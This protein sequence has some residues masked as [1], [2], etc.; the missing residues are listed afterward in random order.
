MCRPIANENVKDEN[1]MTRTSVRICLFICMFACGAIAQA[2]DWYVSPSGSSQGNGSLTSPWDLR[3]ALSA[4]AAVQP[5]DT[6][7]VRGGTY[8]GAFNSYLSGR[9]SSPIVVRQN[10]GERA[11][12]AGAL[13][14]GHHGD[15]DVW[16]WGFEVFNRGTSVQSDGVTI[17]ASGQT[18]SGFKLINMVIHDNQVNGVSFWAGAV[19]GEV[20][21][22]LIYNN[23]YDGCVGSSCRGHGHGLYVQST[24]SHR[25]ADNIVFRNFSEGTQLYGSANAPRNNVTYEGNVFFNSGE[26]SALNNGNF[27]S[28]NMYIGGDQV[29]QN[30]KLISNYCYSSAPSGHNQYYNLKSSNNAIVTGN[31]FFTPAPDRQGIYINSNSNTGLQMTGN[32][33][34]GALDFKSSSHPN[35]TY[36]AERPAGKYIFVRPNQY[37]I[38]R[39][40]IVIYNWDLSPSVSVDISA[41]GLHSGQSY[42]IRDSQN[43][44]GPPVATGIYNGSPATIPMSNLSLAPPEGT[45]PPQPHHTAPEFDVFILLPIVSR[46]APPQNLA[47]KIL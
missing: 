36:L 9:A 13:V 45:V 26:L 2:H 32:T 16:F 44:Y 1:T 40:N 5:G 10:P 14:L 20:Y 28:Y 7:W 8:S 6:I 47:I 19:Q 12:I 11:T 35:N 46:L 17:S 37:E 18:N 43:F 15:H 38:G 22:N 33:F 41:S 34:Y 39:A 4:P 30:T 23:G 25:I 31:Y 3:T 24:D 21:G 42:E 29:S 27:N